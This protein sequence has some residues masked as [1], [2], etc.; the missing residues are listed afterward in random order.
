MLSIKELAEYMGLSAQT[1][2]NRFYAGKFPIHAKKIGRLVKF[3][4]KTVDRYLD[5]LAEIRSDERTID[6]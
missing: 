2:R 6:M 3:D 5:S 1:I 4:K